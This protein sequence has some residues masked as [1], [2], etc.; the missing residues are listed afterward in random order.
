MVQR[1]FD[2]VTVRVIPPAVIVQGALG[3]GVMRDA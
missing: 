3:D 1:F 2:I